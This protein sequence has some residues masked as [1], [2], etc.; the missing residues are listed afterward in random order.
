MK[1]GEALE[2]TKLGSSI[3]R[4]GW[5][6]GGMCVKA[7]FPDKHSKMTHPYL[8]IF[9]PGCSEGDRRLPWQPAQVDLFADDWSV[10]L[11]TAS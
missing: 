11:G 2:A 9:V 6:G 4:K 8:Y 7:Q 3:Q 1:F 5:N 10:L